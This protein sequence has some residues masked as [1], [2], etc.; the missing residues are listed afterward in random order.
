MEDPVSIVDVNPLLAAACFFLNIPMKLSDGSVGTCGG[1]GGTGSGPPPFAKNLTT[2]A[3]DEDLC[4][5]EPQNGM[6]ETNP[7]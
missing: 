6:L 3:I 4:P 2:Q 7:R 5:I 1:G